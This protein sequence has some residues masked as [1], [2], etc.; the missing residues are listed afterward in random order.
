MITYIDYRKFLGNVYV[1]VMTFKIIS[2][3]LITLSLTI[4][5]ALFH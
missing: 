2:V 3:S 4:L 5:V 1:F